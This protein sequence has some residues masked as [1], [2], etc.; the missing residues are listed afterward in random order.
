MNQQRESR[1][2]ALVTV[3]FA[4][5][6][7]GAGVAYA[8]LHRS[9]ESGGRGSLV[10]VGFTCRPLP[11]LRGRDVAYAALDAVAA[12]LLERG[13]R[14]VELVLDDERLPLDLAERRSL[15]GA[16]IVPYVALRCRLNR[17][18]FVQVKAACDGVA[19][20]LTAWARAEVSLHV[21]A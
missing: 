20:D 21:A 1:Q 8:V 10:R 18:G 9:A 5:D 15:P 6:A 19:R 13:I 16:L 17:F 11:S 4:A 7:D 14:R 12:A 3:G 2:L